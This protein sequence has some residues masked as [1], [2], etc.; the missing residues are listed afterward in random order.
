MR[1]KV[2]SLALLLSLALFTQAAAATD[3]QPPQQIIPAHWSAE[4]A[5]AFALGNS[6]ETEIALQQIASAEAMAQMADATSYPLVSLSSQYSMTNN[7]MYSFGNILNQG[8][9]DNSIDFNDPGRTDALSLTAQTQYRIYNGGRDTASSRAAEAGVSMAQASRVEVRQLLA[10]E[11]VKGYEAILE[12]QQ[13]LQVRYDAQQAIASSRRVAQERWASG[14]LLKREL[15]ALKAE[16]AQ[17]GASL[18]AAENNLALARQSFL[19]LLGLSNQEISL[20][21]SVDGLQPPPTLDITRRQ[22]YRQIEAQEE[23]ARAQLQV[24]AGGKKPT[25]DAFGNYE[26]EYGP[27]LDGDGNSWTAGIKMNYTLFDGH[28]TDAAIAAAQAKVREITAK[29]KRLALNLNLEL[30]RARLNLDK[31]GRRL[32]V[33]QKAEEAAAEAARLS[34]IQFKEGTVLASDLIDYEVSLSEARARRLTANAE[35]IVALANLRR[36]AGYGQFETSKPPKA[37]N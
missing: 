14:D 35:K 17:A 11:V 7:A 6:P 22:L 2:L 30:E 26:V 32:A 19:T 10:F 36:A 16:E 31:A 29:K 15:L 25:V 23:Q 37:E 5:V 3:S 21:K 33:T 12:A 34:R 24:A 13:M 4:E 18:I 27:E 1:K 28:S 9:F 8:A 20:K